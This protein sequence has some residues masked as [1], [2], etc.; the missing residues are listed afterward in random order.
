M[1]LMKDC[2]RG[3]TYDI[4]HAYHQ[5]TGR[6]LRISIGASISVTFCNLRVQV[7]KY[8]VCIPNHHNCGASYRNHRYFLY[9]RSLDP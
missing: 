2:F 1:H 9:W 3:H 7:P 5:A 8:E 6:G 4:L